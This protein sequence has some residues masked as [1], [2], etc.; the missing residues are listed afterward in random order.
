MLFRSITLGGLRRRIGFVGDLRSLIDL[1]R[2]LRQLRP[3]IVHTHMAKAGV[4]GRIAALLARVP[5]RVHTYHG[6][7]LHGY[8]SPRVSRLVTRVERVLS[9]IT[10]WHFVV[11]AHTRDDL[12]REGVVQN[13]NSSVILPAAP[14]VTPL[15]RHDARVRL[16][17]PVDATVVGFVGRLTSV[18]RPD[19]F[20]A[21]ATEHPA[22]QFVIF[23][24]GPLRENVSR[25][26]ARLPN[27][28]LLGWQQN[29]S[30]IHGALDIIVLT[31][32]NEG[33]PLSLLEAASGGVAILAMDIGGIR[34]IITDGVT[35]TLAHD[36][37]QLA[38]RLTNL[39]S[40][41]PY[42]RSMASAARA[43]V[44]ARFSAE[45]YVRA[46]A[47]TYQNLVRN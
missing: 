40:D 32:D 7:L 30:L 46:H 21:L 38:Q 41:V 18:K 27:V 15:N 33:I 13:E 17:L 44:L 35:G 37:E 19:R 29:L 16:G 10:H 1:V 4:L 26:A 39:L 47:E 20:L 11:G 6:H 2:L 45:A 24:D 14:T 8:F 43:D 25:V 23:G 31:S 3:D 22:T 34:E 36:D 12:L 5:I 9:R 42:R 28:R